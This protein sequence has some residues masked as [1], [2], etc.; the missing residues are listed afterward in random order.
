MSDPQ[1][2]V[3][4]TP[5][6]YITIML[7]A[8]A[9]FSGRSV[10]RAFPANQLIQEHV[11]TSTPELMALS[12]FVEARKLLIYCERE[13]EFREV[14]DDYQLNK[15]ADDHRGTRIMAR[16]PSRLPWPSRRLLVA[17][18]VLDLIQKAAA[19][20]SRCI[21]L[22]LEWYTASLSQTISL[23]L[24][25]KHANWRRRPAGT[26]QDYSNDRHLELD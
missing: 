22:K 25:P 4:R 11:S 14:W 2:L 5:S 1:N 21:T 10:V 13:R 8:K 26:G 24:A 20:R 17:V 15:L 7:T 6:G 9:S 3:M 19:D 16:I 12:L 18:H 23:F